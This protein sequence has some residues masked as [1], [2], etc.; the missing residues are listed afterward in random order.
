MNKG[1][2]VILKIGGSVVTEKDGEL[3]ARTQII[4]RLVEEILD[5]ETENLVLIHGGGS[6]GHPSAERYGIRDGFQNEA[7]KI[8]FTETHHFMTML[9]GL[10]MDALVWHHMPSVSITPS[11]CIVTEGKRIQY[12]DDTFLKTFMKMGF[13]PVLYGDAVLDSKIGFTILSGDQLAANLAIRLEAERVIMG[14]DV[15]GLFVTDPKTDGNA[16]RFSHL[17]FKEF[18]DLQNMIGKPTVP[19][20]TGGMRGKIA[21]LLPVVEKGIPV[22]FVNAVK[23]DYVFRALRAE[24]VDSTLVERE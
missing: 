6:F 14:V 8:G 13:L 10:F 22:T 24:S 4:S 21:E 20:V 17:N 2:P 18:K 16:K 9:N 15:D 7:Q 19:D 5:S 12:F 1:K 3:T 11:S 23:P